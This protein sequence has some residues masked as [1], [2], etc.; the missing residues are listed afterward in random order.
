VKLIVEDRGPGMTRAFIEE[1]LF[2]PFRSTKEAGFGVGAYEARELI[3]AEGGRLKVESEMGKGTRMII[4]LPP[5]RAL[6]KPGPAETPS[7]PVPA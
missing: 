2:K 3:R 1:D 6:A 5:Q 4:E 7:A